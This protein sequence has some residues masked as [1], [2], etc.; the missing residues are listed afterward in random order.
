M[1]LLPILGREL[2]ARS[3]GQAN[4][5]T[6][7]CVALAGVLICIESMQSNVFGT[8][9][10][11]GSFVFNG[12]VGAAFLVSCSAC[13]L[14][15]DA[16][17]GEWR[18]GT[19]GLL[20]LTRVRVL[21]VLIGKLGSIGFAAICALAAF[22][23]VLMVPILAGGI[24][25]GEAFRKG[26][27]LLDGLFLALVI[28]L[29]SS[30][31]ERDRFPAVRK[32]MIG[33][34]LV[35]LIP[36]FA[37]VGWGRGLFFFLGLFSPL[38]LLIR[39]GD[40]AYTTSAW[41]YWLSLLAVQAVSWFLLAYGGLRLRRAVATECAGAGRKSTPPEEMTKRAVG[42]GVWRPIKEEASPVEWL[43]HRQYG[44][45]AGIWG[46][47][48][49]ALACNSWV[50]LVRQ[51]Q[52]HP[53]GP[54]FLAV[55]SPLGT[56]AGLIGGAAV[57]WVASR[58]FVGVRRTGDLELL[59][60]TPVGADTVLNDQWRV[61]KRLFVWPVL[62]MQAPMLPRFLVGL[63]ALRTTGPGVFDPTLPFLKMLTIANSFFGAAAMCWLG[64]WFGLR[65]RSQATAI[66]WSVGLGQGVTGLLSLLCS[67]S[68]GA[69][70]SRTGT[71]AT[72]YLLGWWIPELLCLSYYLW[73]TA[74]ARRSLANDIAGRQR[75]ILGLSK[76]AF[77][78]PAV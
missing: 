53:V 72:G 57:A 43:V 16:I 64:L 7:F 75:P 17:S 49:L 36:F 41:P 27:G 78:K 29:F 5:W 11:M 42:L 1:T 55:A 74:I 20:F 15:A 34:A 31:A 19:L 4:Y 65:S 28:G 68:A 52:G 66:V 32:S 22:L 24:T 50:P 54:F 71:Q 60:T 48:V 13:L 70:I 3:R 69:S 6:R 44:I 26:L 47:A 8:P 76:S 51:A 61:L 59:L 2:Q 25:G 18:E 21:D 63:S 35:V 30:A 12:I 73:V 39:A 38:V 62:M 33:L 37:Y 40:M 14:T 23:P 77:L 67:I 56:V 46:I 45:H 58:F 10:M 9:A